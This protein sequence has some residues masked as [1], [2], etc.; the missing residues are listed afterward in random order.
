MSSW[1]V[2]FVEESTFGSD[3]DQFSLFKESSLSENRGF[4]T[5]LLENFKKRQIREAFVLNLSPKPYV[6]THFESHL[7]SRK[8][9]IIEKV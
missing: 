2:C 9:E 4:Q 6:N 5:E 3:R 8:K 7:S 1:H